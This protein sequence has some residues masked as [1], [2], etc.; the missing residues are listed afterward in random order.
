MPAIPRASTGGG[1]LASVQWSNGSSYTTVSTSPV[2]VD[3]TNAKITFTAPA[4]GRVRI[5][6]LASATIQTPVAAHM[7]DLREGGVEVTGSA[8]YVTKTEAH[9]CRYSRLFTGL[10]GTHTYT[11]GFWTLDNTKTATIHQ[12]ATDPPLLMEAWAA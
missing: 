6:L 9:N 11:W 3:A 8:S 2:D 7:W 5:V 12:S 1:A 4:S 10:S